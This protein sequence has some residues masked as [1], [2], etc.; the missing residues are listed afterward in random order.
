MIPDFFMQLSDAL[1]SVSL[2]SRTDFQSLADVLDPA[3]I[4]QGLNQAGV[5]TIRRRKLPMESMV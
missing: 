3:L 2:N 5:A 1:A 4:E